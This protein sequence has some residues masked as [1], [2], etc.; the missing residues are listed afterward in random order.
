MLGNYITIDGVS[1]RE[2][3]L[4]CK[5][6]PVYPIAMQGYNVTTVGG[7][8]EN[9]FQ[10]SGHYNDIQIDIEAVLI[11]FDID[12]IVKWISTGKELS[13]SNQIDKFVLIKQLVAI[14]QKRAGNGALEL[15]ITVKCSPFKYSAAKETIVISS[16][17][18]YFKT[19]GNIYSEPIINAI[20]CSEGFTMALNGVTITTTG[21]T[22]DIVFDVPNRA[23]FQFVDGVK[24]VVQ[25]HTS[26]NIWDLLLVP[27]ETEYNSLVFSGAQAVQIIE[28]ERWI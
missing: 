21:L 20:G 2:Y 3:G 5:Q 19:I 25:E 17:P 12:N 23:V 9:L 10:A 6:L 27:S 13:F 8:L 1:S 14:D 18:E 16:S 26:G 24:T 22:G 7:R 15:K 11:G 4:F 28:N